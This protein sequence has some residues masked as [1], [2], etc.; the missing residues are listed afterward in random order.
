MDIYTMKI[1]IIYNDKPL[2]IDINKLASIH[3]L[4]YLIF[5]KTNIDV[6][7]Q[8]L[9]CNGKV[10][11]NNDLVCTPIRV[12]ERLDGGKK[13]QHYDI[14]TIL[15][16]LAY[17]NLILLFIVLL[18]SGLLTV[19]AHLY[20]FALEWIL[21]VIGSIT[22][23]DQYTIYKI[24]KWIF[25]F[26]IRIFIIYFFIYASSAFIAYPFA[27]WY[28]G[29]YCEGIQSANWVGFIVAI[30]FIIIYGIMNIPD[31][32]TALVKSIGGLSDITKLIVNPLVGFLDEVID[33]GKYIFLYPIPGLGA[34][35]EGYFF[36]VDF[37]TSSIKKTEAYTKPYDCE[38]E[39][40]KNK[41]RRLLKLWENY[42]GI[43]EQVANFH[44][45]DIMEAVKIRFNDKDFAKLQC[46]YENLPVWNR[47]NPFHALT[48]KYFLANYGTGG[49]CFV[50][51]VIKTITG[52]IGKI[53]GPNQV[54]NMIKSGSVAGVFSII[55][56]LIM[57][58]LIICHVV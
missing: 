13:I 27:H 52:M 30:V 21:D 34:V 16:W 9:Y 57:F 56:L 45:E 40:G 51:Q 49:F 54:A 26:I 11:Q 58:I 20:E 8:I 43:S 53:G 10:L 14:L 12:I 2:F 46:D 15:F 24:I 36:G 29:S 25:V 47:Y 44:L 7:K 42:P 48:G 31:E 22:T 35:F 28:K 37:T 17:I 19:V 33:T 18:F 39:E 32:I 23:I 5:E 41:I 1:E 50:L 38:T 4:K 3:E 6:D 55:A